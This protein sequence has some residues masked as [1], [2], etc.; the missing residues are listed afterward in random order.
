MIETRRNFSRRILFR[1]LFLGV[2]VAVILFVSYGY[3]ND[4]YLKNQLTPVGLVINSG[5]ILAFLL[6][7]IKVISSLWYYMN[8]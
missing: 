2:I 8:E 4:L 5:I 3:V 7:L 6:G 1:L